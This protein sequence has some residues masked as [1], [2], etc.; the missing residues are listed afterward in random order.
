MTFRE[1]SYAISDFSKTIVD[2]SII[3]IDHIL[4]VMSKYRNY[5]LN[6]QFAN[7]KKQPSDSNYQQIC[8]PLTADNGTVDFCGKEDVLRSIDKVPYTMVNLG[9]HTIYPPAGFIYG[10][11]QLVN[12]TK[13]KYSGH[14]PYLGNMVY[15][16]IGPDDHLY[17]KS[18]NKD[19]LNL[20]KVVMSAIFEDPEKAALMECDSD[21][22]CADNCDLMDKRFP[23]DDSYLPLLMQFCV[24]DI[25]GA[26][27][28]P[29]DDSNNASDDLARFAQILNRY[30]T[31]SF[32]NQMNAQPDKDEQQL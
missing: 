14:N 4:F 19:F 23:L 11:F 27:W 10:N 26:A 25:T 28:K 3:T 17:L 21:G 24:R 30:T 32:K 15:A 5:I 9:A 2:D 31:Q 6:S 13:F 18:K 22:K 29:S 12:N 7:M 16:T 1:V 8:I 20:S